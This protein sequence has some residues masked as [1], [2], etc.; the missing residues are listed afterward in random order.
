MGKMV[1]TVLGAVADLEKNLIVE[2]PSRIASCS[3]K[4]NQARKAE[5]ID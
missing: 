5:E 1:F 4:R 3:G 2:R